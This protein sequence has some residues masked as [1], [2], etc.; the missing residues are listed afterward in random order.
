MNKKLNRIMAF[1]LAALF[2]TSAFTITALA[3]DPV[4]VTINGEYITFPEGDAQPI[5]YNS[6]AM[7]PIRT[8]AEALGLTVEWDKASEKATFKT[9]DGSRVITHTMRSNIIFVNNVMSSFDTPSI[10]RQDRILVPIRMLAEAMGAEVSW[11]NPSRT[12]AI[13]TDADKASITSA[14]FAETEI[15]EG[16][17]AE[18]ICITNAKTSKIRLYDQTAVKD[19]K[20]VTDYTDNGD[21]SRTFR[22]TFTPDASG[23]RS[24]SLY[25]NNGTEDGE[26]K[27]VTLK[28]NENTKKDDDSSDD[29]LSEY[30]E[31][32]TLEEKTV[33][34]GDYVE[35]T[36]VT[37]DE[38]ERVR[39]ETKNGS[40]Y[41]TV[42]EYAETSGKRKFQGKIRAS[43]AGSNSLYIYV[44]TDKIGKYTTDFRVVN[45]KVTG[46]DDD[47]DASKTLEIFDIYPATNVV[48]K[49]EE[50]LIYVYTTKDIDYIEVFDEDNDKVASTNYRY[51]E[52]TSKNV[53]ALSWTQTSSGSKKFKVIAYDEDDASTSESIRI[54]CETQTSGP[55]VISI[56]PK[57]DNIET[58]SST[59]F[60][61]KCSTDTDYV[62]IKDSNGR[63]LYSTEGSTT[64]AGTTYTKYSCRLDITEVN[65]YYTIYAYDDDGNVYTREFYVYGTTYEEPEIL[66]VDYDTTIYEGDSVDVEV[67]TNTSVTRVWI[68]DKDG[69]NVTNKLKTP[70]KSYDD[71]LVWRFNFEPD[72]RGTNSYTIYASNEDTDADEDYDF[73]TIRIKVQ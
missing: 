22:I 6:R 58:G 34:K 55:Y 46:D 65:D 61:A 15:T 42:S 70:S 64:T 40:N 3:D 4:Y 50:C 63:T 11:D 12:V 20:E 69:D 59:T 26:S 54:E 56:E 49:K 67:I 32:V 13:K 30:I 53:W 41:T 17:E 31:K 27:S 57:S 10:V 39:V 71:E 72:D 38:V 52:L 66:D 35:F 45:F 25:P 2:V 21:G 5:I 8:T 37:T 48:T 62:V 18:I 9:S 28:V 19:V 1:L 43:V 51:E 73:K 24:Y 7:V 44:Y 33:E 29:G 36:V 16:D 14:I 23:S 68:E 47:D 60:I